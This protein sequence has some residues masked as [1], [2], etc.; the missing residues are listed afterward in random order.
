MREFK[1]IF[2]IVMDSVGIGHAVD[3][4]EY[5]DFGKPNTLLNIDQAIGGLKLPNLEKLGLGNYDNYLYIR[6]E[7]QIK[8][9]FAARLHEQSKAKDT[10]AGHWEIMG[11]ETT[12]P[13]KTFEENGF[14][15]A[16]IDELIAK[17]GRGVL[18][19]Y[20]ASGTQIIADLGEEHMK[21][22]KLIVYTSSDSVL[23]IAAHE[24]IIP[25][26]ELYRYCEIAR[27]ITLKDDWKVGRIIARPFIG[28]NAKNF[29]RTKRR[30]DY[31]L[32]PFKDTYLDLI[33]EKSYDV[34]A[35]GKIND[36]YNGCGITEVQK[37]LN[38]DDG[39]DKTT[40]L[41][42]KSDSFHGLCFVNLV[43]FDMEFGHRRNVE[44]YASCLEKF[45]KRLGE[46]L[47]YLKEDDLLILTADHGNDPTQDGTNHTRET[48]PGLFYSPSFKKGRYLGEFKTF[49]MIGATVAANFG[50]RS[51]DL[52]GE[53]L[54]HLLE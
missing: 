36:I 10:L 31:A 8:E 2:L 32:S 4:E 20:A 22:G 49:A 41:A 42:K 40:A 18:G 23:Q 33:K 52:L 27:E 47:K 19:N 14:P 1:R 44:G 45:D 35:I 51:S 5:G 54:G 46:L 13:F 7:K 17:T 26:P 6:P 11:L 53:N 9:A 16:L 39:M 21:T 28:T 30:H 38:N 29:K 24:E 15:K 43:D 50:I 25:V 34:V 3:A 37:T 48:V 12:K